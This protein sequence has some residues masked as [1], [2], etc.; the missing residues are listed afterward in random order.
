MAVVVRDTLP[1]ESV[2]WVMMAEA[3]AGGIVPL[4]GDARKAVGFQRSTVM[5]TPT[6][7]GVVFQLA[8]NW[9]L[10]VAIMKC[11]RRTPRR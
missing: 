2:T 4:R 8:K 7:A 10:S 3:W 1:R 11:R 5:P 9:N 6:T